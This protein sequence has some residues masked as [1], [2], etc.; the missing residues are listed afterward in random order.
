MISYTFSSVLWIILIGLDLAL[1]ARL[2]RMYRRDSDIRKLMF[3]IGL[4]M[5]INVYAIAIVGI[6]SFSL[7]RNI[8]EWSPLPLLLAF[9]L[10]S[11]LERRKPDS[12]KFY[13]F[14]M[15]GTA[16]A[17]VMFF[18]PAAA[19]LSQP[20]LVAGLALAILVSI[21]EYSKKFDLP[22]ATL[23]LSLPS[24]AFSYLAIGQGMTELALFASFAAKG[25]LLVAFEISKSQEGETT[26]ILVLKKE[27]YTA[28]HN[29]NKL[30]NMLPDPA[31][32]VDAK[33]TILAVSP[34]I[35]ALSGLKK[36]ELVGANF[37]K[38]EL[39]SDSSKFKMVQHLGSTMIDREI[40][41]YEIEVQDKDGKKGQYEVNTSKTSYRGVTA[42][43]VVFRD[44]TERNRLLE[45]IELEQ[46]RFQDIAERTGDWIWELDSEGKFIYSNP[47]AS[48]TIGYTSEEII[49]KKASDIFVPS[50]EGNAEPF[51]ESVA[52][53]CSLSSI[54]R[55]YSLRDGRVLIMEIQAMPMQGANGELVGYRGVSRDF[56]E[57]QEMEKRLLKAERFAA[58]GELSTMVAHDLRNPLQGISNVIH[59]LKKTTKNAGN[60]KL[61]SLIPLAEEA[62]KHAENIVRELLDYSANIQLELSEANPKSIVTH[63][64]SGMVIPDN[65]RI[66]DKTQPKPMVHVDSDKI[67]R[68]IV[69]LAMNAFDAMPT[70][71]IL[72][73]ISKASEGCL[74]LSIADSGIGISDEK[75]R[76]LWAPF[77]T[78]KA[79]GIGLG[80]PICKRIVDAHGGRILCES[81]KGKGTTFTLILPILEKVEKNVEFCVSGQEVIGSES[82]DSPQNG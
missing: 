42:A 39:I 72:T 24:F 78:T 33:G 68:V 54:I 29:F 61:A 28:E 53:A 56:T 79:K 32:I 7:A 8:L 14:F 11:L 47:V 13:K 17:I 82:R 51:L 26:S 19:N 70:G 48:K 64:L 5:F 34:G 4:L 55:Q 12:N 69:N 31:T 63:A 49:G 37:L 67:T 15:A 16:F 9:I 74:E 38:I 76:K 23:F 73:I 27:L 22:S 41:P 36:E 21:F 40:P 59:Y 46:M 10:T 2:A 20:V 3:I 66:L 81:E 62:L 71:G 44:L 52:G 35:I 18:V 58:I 30:F 50:V 25:A 45:K 75:M 1:S 65:I 77:V 6:D 43:M 60:E 80:L 57:K